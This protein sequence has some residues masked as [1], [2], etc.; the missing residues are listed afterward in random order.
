MHKGDPMKAYKNTARNNFKLNKDNMPS[1]KE[2]EAVII[3]EE[4]TL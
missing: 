4:Q 2:E 3:V 1:K